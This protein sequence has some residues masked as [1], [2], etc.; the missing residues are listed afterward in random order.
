[1]VKLLAFHINLLASL[2][3]WSTDAEQAML[4]L[5]NRFRGYSLAHRWRLHG[6]AH[7]IRAKL[8]STLKQAGLFE[9]AFCG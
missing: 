5:G 4:I 7:S 6:V 2:L 8:F 3:R 1:M 9:G